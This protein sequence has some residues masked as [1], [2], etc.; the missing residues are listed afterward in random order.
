MLWSLPELQPLLT[1]VQLDGPATTFG[2]ELSSLWTAALS[3]QMEPSY[4]PQPDPVAR[5]LEA[6]PALWDLP[7]PRLP[8]L[9]NCLG[10]Q[11]SSSTCPSQLHL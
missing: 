1:S 11:S 2:L 6:H 3:A 8:L 4:R 5:D 7:A 9:A 10:P